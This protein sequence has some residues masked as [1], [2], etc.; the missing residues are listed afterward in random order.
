M[1]VI[2]SFQGDYR[3]LSNFYP[4]P[5]QYEG[6]RYP[7][8]EHAYQGAKTLNI[9]QRCVVA[10]F[11]TPGGA[12]RYGKKLE[13]REDWEDIK[14]RVM[15]RLLLTKFRP[16]SMLAWKLELT[17]DAALIEGNWWGDT[18]WG[19]CRG[20]G[21]NHLGRLLMSIRERNRTIHGKERV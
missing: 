8:V 18:F 7:S 1:K 12:K 14:L 9:R 21:E 2:D 10:S 4:S 15:A 5:L 16:T 19:V 3:Y 6:I 11:E 17:G 13:L 20:E